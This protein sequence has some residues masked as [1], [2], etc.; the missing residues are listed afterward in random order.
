M[1]EADRKALDRVFRQL[2][3]MEFPQLPPLPDPELL[4]PRHKDI[5][6]DDALI[7]R[8]AQTEAL[9]FSVDPNVRGVGLGLRKRRGEATGEKALVALVEKKLPPRRVRKGCMLPR[10]IT[11]EGREY[12]VDVQEAPHLAPRLMRACRPW[13]RLSGGCSGSAI[14]AD[15]GNPCGGGTL[16]GTWR[17]SSGSAQR[18]MTCAHVALGWGI[19]DFLANLPVSLLWLFQSPDGAEIVASDGIQVGQTLHRLMEIDTDWWILVPIPLPLP[20]P[21]AA[22]FVYVDAAAGRVR[23]AVIPPFRGPFSFATAPPL[24]PPR[25]GSLIGR[26]IRTARIAL[27]G[28]DVM[29]VGQTTGLT[30]GSVSISFLQFFLPVPLGPFPIFVLFDQIVA[31]MDIGPGDSGAALVTD[32][33]HFLG[34]CWGGLPLGVGSVTPPTPPGCVVRPR[35]VVGSTLATPY[36]WSEALMNLDLS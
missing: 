28:Q 30:F 34:H 19:E 6:R 3:R 21:G 36:Y 13:P 29:K 11:C 17:A 33:M 35:D 2:K 25:R 12:P 9:R 1:V 32:D 14:Y 5:P 27:P 26:R 18:G 7:A 20:L 10:T 23:P 31:D 22:G 8:Y 15:G 24:A 4:D 16:T